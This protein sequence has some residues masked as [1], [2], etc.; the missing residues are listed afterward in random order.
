[1]AHIELSIPLKGKLVMV[2]DHAPD[3][4]HEV[5]SFEYRVPVKFINQEDVGIPTVEWLDGFKP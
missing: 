1:M 3:K 2:F 4:Q 5:A